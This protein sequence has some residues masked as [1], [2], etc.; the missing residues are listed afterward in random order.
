MLEKLKAVTGD[1]WQW[2][3][4]I[5]IL[6][7][8]TVGKQLMI[9]AIQAVAAS[10]QQDGWSNSD[11]RKLAYA[12]ISEAMKHAGYSVAESIINMAIEI[13]VAQMKSKV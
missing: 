6:L 1:V 7:I 5:A 8:T 9:A 2:I 3:R 13:A 12:S 4:P 11:K 10:A